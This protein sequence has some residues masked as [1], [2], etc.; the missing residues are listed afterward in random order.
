MTIAD[1]IRRHGSA[2]LT[3]FVGAFFLALFADKLWP[4]TF[5]IVFF[6]LSAFWLLGGATAAFQEFRSRDAAVFSDPQDW[7]CAELPREFRFI[8]RDTTLENLATELGPY[9]SVADTGAV[10]YD[11]PSGGAIFIYSEPP[12]ASNSKVRGIQ[13]YRSRDS[14]PVFPL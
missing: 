1:R 13:L 3:G 8:T 11:L 6:A 7:V 10:R 2:L 4:G 14:V 5:H 12:F 9:R